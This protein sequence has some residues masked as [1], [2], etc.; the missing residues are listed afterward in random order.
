MDRDLIQ[1][2]ID[3][4][5]AHGDFAEKDF[6]E[7]STSRPYKD[8]FLAGYASIRKVP[9]YER[10]LPLLRLKKAI[11]TIGFTVRKGIWQSKGK[12]CISLVAIT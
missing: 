2:I 6:V 4:S 5:S 1:G 8:P 10:T 9:S 12:K 7:W 11:G 3:K